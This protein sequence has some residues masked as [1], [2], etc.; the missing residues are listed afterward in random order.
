V[1]GK[2]KYHSLRRFPAFARSSFWCEYFKMKINKAEDMKKD[3][4]KRKERFKI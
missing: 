3:R 4:K 1:G 2:I